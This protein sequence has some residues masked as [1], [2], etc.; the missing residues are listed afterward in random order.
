MAHVYLKQRHRGWD[1]RVGKSFWIQTSYFVRET[2]GLG[3]GD[4]LMQWQFLGDLPCVQIAFSARLVASQS[5]F[6]SITKALGRDVFF[7][8]H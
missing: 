3:D 6:Y 1:F 4:V 8:T 7:G 5:L 2:C